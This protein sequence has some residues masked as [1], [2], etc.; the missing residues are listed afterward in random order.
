MKTILLLLLPFNI[1]AQTWTDTIPDWDHIEKA[2]I[3]IQYSGDWTHMTEKI[4][5]YPDSD[6]SIA[7]YRFWGQGIDIYTEVAR[8]H[9]YYIVKLDGVDLDTINVSGPNQK[10]VMTFSIDS[11]SY[12]KLTGYNHDLEIRSNKACGFVLDY[13]IKHVD[14]NPWPKDTIAPNL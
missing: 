8:H 11:L 5:S 6:S 7:L 9:S 4:G 10:T 13:F 2:N 14:S 1:F 12:N 3:K